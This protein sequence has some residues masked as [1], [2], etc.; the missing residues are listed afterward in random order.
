MIRYYLS[1][2]LRDKIKCFVTTDDVLLLFCGSIKNKYK[3][4]QMKVVPL[5]REYRNKS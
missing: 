5:N 1:N 4:E 2:R 3:S